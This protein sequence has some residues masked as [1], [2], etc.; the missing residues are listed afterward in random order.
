M[1]ALTLALAAIAGRAQQVAAP[2]STPHPAEQAPK[3]K[4]NPP[5]AVKRVEAHYSDEARKKRINGD[6]LVS[7]TVDANGM[8]QDV[9]LVRCTDPSFE[10]SS[11]DGVAKY[12]FRPATTQL[13]QPV[14][15]KITVE[16]A[17][18]LY[19]ANAP[20]IPVCCSFNPPPGPSS[21]GPGPDGV[22]ALT[23]TV[24]PPILT[25]FSEGDYGPDAFAA[26]RDGACDIVLTISKKGKPSD[27]VVTHCGA[28]DLE[29]PAVQ[30]LLKSK[31]KPG[32]VNGKAVA[33]RASIHLE[34]GGDP[35]RP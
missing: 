33:I 16:V 24:A 13:G 15:A 5:T 30:S 6:C 35:P 23:K 32:S 11:L 31:Y 21:S 3:E 12:R 14:P 2:A 18:R 25:K 34:Y 29:K 1:I 7:L 4:I 26:G 19:G 28:S 22:Y 10:Q 20:E 17:Y 9:A 8:P 27:P